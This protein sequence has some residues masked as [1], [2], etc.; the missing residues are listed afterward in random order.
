MNMPPLQLVESF[1][2]KVV[3]DAKFDGVSTK[4]V[5]PLQTRVDFHK[6]KNPG[7]MLV[8]LGDRKSVV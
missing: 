8:R 6:G 4:E 1:Y 7:E 5:F 2:S 3:V